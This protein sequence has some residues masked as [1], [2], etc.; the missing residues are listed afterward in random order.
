[1]ISILGI[2]F[3]LFTAF[4]LSENRKAITIAN[5]SWCFW[6]QL[7]LGSIV[8]YYSWGQNALIIV[9]AKVQNVIDYAQ[10]GIKFCWVVWFLLKCT[11][12]LVMVDLCLL[13]VS[14]LL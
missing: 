13:F 8:L 7:L 4:L 9:S 2:V 10:D 11:K 12:H 5:S 3:L 6:N 14:F 1:M